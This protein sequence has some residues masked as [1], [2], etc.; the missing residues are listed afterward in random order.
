MARTSRYSQ[1]VRERAVRMV[2]EGG[3]QSAWLYETL[4]P[5]VDEIV[6][7]GVTKSRGQKNDRRD[8]Y[9]L[10]EVLRTGALEKRIFKAPRPRESRSATRIP[11]APTTNGCSRREPSRVSPS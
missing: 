10:A 6:V 5:H 11:S 4:C 7:A 1:E 2:F 9:G 8:A 3:L